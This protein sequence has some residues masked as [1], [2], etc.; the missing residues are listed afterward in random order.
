MTKPNEDPENPEWTPE[1]VA[2]AQ[3]GI[4]HLPTP[5]RGAIENT[6]RGRG[7]Q[8]AP[9]KIM[10]TLRLEPTTVAAYKSTGR[11]W[12]TRIDHDLAKTAPRVRM[13]STNR[14]AEVRAATSTSKS[15][16][17]AS[18]AFV[19]RARSIG[20]KAAAKKR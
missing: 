1:M 5:V 4:A 20:R 12:Q 7:P 18:G 10:V 15:T 3:R 11:G 16:T 14:G 8:R 13:V 6:R 2:R 17:Q 19:Q 9:K